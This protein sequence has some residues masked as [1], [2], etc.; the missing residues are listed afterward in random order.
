MILFRFVRY[1]CCSSV[2]M[3]KHHDGAAPIIKFLKYVIYICSQ[4]F[5]GHDT[6]RGEVIV[7]ACASLSHTCAEMFVCSLSRGGYEGNRISYPAVFA[8]P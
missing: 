3:H 8:L 5:P 7:L 2:H 1:F 6:S 4:T